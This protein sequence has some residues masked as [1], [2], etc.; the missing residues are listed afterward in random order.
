MAIE[1]ECKYNACQKLIVQL[2]VS[3]YTAASSNYETINQIAL[4][5]QRMLV[6]VV[7]Y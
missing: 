1:Y 7:V 6:L 4:V 3:V 2:R 5:M